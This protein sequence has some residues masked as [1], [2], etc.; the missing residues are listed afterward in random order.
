MWHDL[1]KHRRLS[2]ILEISTYCNAKCPQCDRTN[3]IGLGVSDKF[4]FTPNINLSLEKFK[5]FFTPEVISHLTNIHFSG[6]F[7]DPLMNPDILEMVQHVIESD[8]RCTVSI[9]TNGSLRNEEFWW[10]LGAVGKKRL[11]VV[12]DVDGITQEMHEKYRRA[13]SLKKILRNMDTLSLTL[14]NVKTF[15][16]LFKHNQDYKEEIEKLC[17]QHGA[18]ECEILQSNRFKDGPIF[19]FINEKGESEVLEQVVNNKLSTREISTGARRV[20]DYRFKSEST[21][22]IKFVRKPEIQ[23]TEK[24]MPEISCYFL[25]NKNLHIDVNGIVYPCCHWEIQNDYIKSHNK[26]TLYHSFHDELDK[27]NLNNYSLKDILS[28]RYFDN[29]IYES[30]KDP[31]QISTPCVYMCRKI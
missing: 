4:R 21:Q 9:N 1:Y 29:G 23:K 12:F 15:T 27:N 8:N 14:A 26:N 18:V 20:R 2:A 30:F 25:N 19:N 22:I 31:D 6:S 7:G 11:T 5:T 13:T 3:P 28:N 16:I 24:K 17:K 10:N